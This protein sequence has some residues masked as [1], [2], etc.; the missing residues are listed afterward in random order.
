MAEIAGV[1]E[2]RQMECGWSEWA[3]VRWPSAVPAVGLVICRDVVRGWGGWLG[4]GGVE[5]C[6]A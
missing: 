2:R 4:R 5:R 6:E 3:F 1:V